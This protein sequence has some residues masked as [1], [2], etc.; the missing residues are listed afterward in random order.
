MGVKQVGRLM[1]SLALVGIAGY[2][3]WAW[4]T[5]PYEL[6]TTTSTYTR[7]MPDGSALMILAFFSVIGALVAAFSGD[8]DS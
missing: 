8:W 7:A 4:A 6:I 2:C 3:A 1:L 5:M